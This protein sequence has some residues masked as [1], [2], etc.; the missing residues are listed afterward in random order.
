[1]YTNN[2]DR[3][4]LGLGIERV[5]YDLNINLPCRSSV[6]AN[7]YVIEAE[8]LLPVLEQLATSG[9]EFSSLVDRNMAAFL[10]SKMERHVQ[11]D[12]RDLDNKVDP[13]IPLIASVKILSTLQERVAKADFV[14]LAGAVAT[15]IEP[16]VERFHSRTVRKRVRGGL[17]KATRTGRLSHLVGTINDPRNVAAD[18]AAFKQASAAYAQTVMEDQWVEYE[19]THREYFAREKGAQMAATVSGVITCI[20]SILIFVFMMFF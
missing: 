6:L 14:D 10:A 8:E 12:L 3:I 18:A 11:A 5:A 9:V 2:L 16:S 13:H 15:M 4:G 20:A 19:K 17:K 1:M 7:D